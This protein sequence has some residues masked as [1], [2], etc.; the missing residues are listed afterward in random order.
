MQ[1]PTDIVA[2]EDRVREKSRRERRLREVERSELKRLLSNELGRTVLMRVIERAGVFR[3]TF[4]A[5][6]PDMSAFLEGQREVGRWLFAQI[7]DSCP[8]LWT[9]MLRER[10]ERIAREKDEEETE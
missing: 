1:D 5:G 6:Q 7:V 3:S 8:E 4:A 2:T 10:A 9:T